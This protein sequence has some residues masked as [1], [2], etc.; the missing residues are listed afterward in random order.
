MREIVQQ[1]RP[2]IEADAS[3]GGVAALEFAAG[4][5]EH[6]HCRFEASLVSMLRCLAA[7]G[8]SEDLWLARSARGLASAAYANGPRPVGE[9]LHWLRDQHGEGAGFMLL[10]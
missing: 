7:A 2:V 4:Y 1:A 10:M 5:L 8:K 6:Y 3:P 9:A